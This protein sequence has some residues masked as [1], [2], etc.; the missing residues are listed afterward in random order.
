M[1][2]FKRDPYNFHGANLQIKYKRGV[3]L[4]QLRR[5]Y[6]S[7]SISPNKAP[8]EHGLGLVDAERW[9]V[10]CKALNLVPE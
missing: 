1:T 4:N 10:I 2:Y 8:H 6:G 7:Q 3:Y 5:V 9:R